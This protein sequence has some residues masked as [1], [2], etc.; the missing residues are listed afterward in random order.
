MTKRDDFV[1]MDCPDARESISAL[2]DG[3]LEDTEFETLEAHL[4]GCDDCRAW[5]ET[6][7]GSAVSLA[8]PLAGSHLK[9]SAPIHASRY[10]AIRFALG[11]AGVLLVAWH[12]PELLTAGNEV[13]VHLSRHQAGFAT[14]LGASFMFV[15]F[16]PDRAYGVIP[17]AASFALVLVVTAVADLING[18]S[19]VAIESR[20]LLEIGGLVLV[21]LLG[22]EMGPERRRRRVDRDQRFSMVPS[23]ETIDPS[24][25]ATE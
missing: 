2:A 20:H 21:L 5:Q 18:S 3:Q 8:G 13:A 16:R 1:R 4:T 7:R 25:N 14:A 12:L 19:N 11:W 22:S 10:R 23:P 6:L 17:F 24:S 9:R 15:A